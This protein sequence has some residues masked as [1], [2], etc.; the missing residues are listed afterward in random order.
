MRTEPGADST[1]QV[2]QVT[3]SVP[4]DVDVD[5][6]LGAPE[7]Q[8]QEPELVL[9]SDNSADAA[10]FNADFAGAPVPSLVHH[11]HGFREQVRHQKCCLC[12]FYEIVAFCCDLHT[13]LVNTCD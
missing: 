13:L 2:V 3:V 7:E 11:G 4:D 1:A 10:V 6:V 8:Q 12:M 5:F 9:A